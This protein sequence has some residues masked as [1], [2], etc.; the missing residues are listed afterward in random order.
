MTDT[1][2]NGTLYTY[3]SANDSYC[4]EIADPRREDELCILHRC[5]VDIVSYGLSA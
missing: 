3:V 1:M 4:R 2:P 5:V